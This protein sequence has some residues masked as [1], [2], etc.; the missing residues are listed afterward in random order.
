MQKFKHWNNIIGWA[1]FVVASA[2]YLMT[3]E[4]T[5]SL[6]DCSEFIATSYKLEVGHPPGAPL[7][8][9]LARIAALFAPTPAD[10]PAMINGMNCIASGFCI[11]FL[12]WTI[13]HLVR[14][15]T[16]REGEPI[17]L[18]QILLILGSGVVGALSYAFTDTFWFSAVEGEVYALSSM[19]TALVVWLMLKWEENATSPTAMRW[20][21]LIAYLMGLSIGVHILN[22]LAIP[23]LV[24]I[25]FFRR[26]ECVN[27]K[28]YILMMLAAIVV[29]FLILGAINGIIIPYTVALG[30]AVDTFAVNT[31]GLPV[32]AGMLIFVAA[33][34][35][36][37]GALVWYTHS[38]RYRL[39]NGIA[40]AVTV[41]LIGFGS[42]AAVAIRANANP[43]M[44]S[45]NPSNPHA[46]LSLLNRD[47]Y[48]NRPLIT[49]P[50][51]S[52]KPTPMVVLNDDTSSDDQ[53]I[54]T[55]EYEAKTMTWLNPETGEYEPREIFSDYKYPSEANA[56]FPRMWWHSRAKQYEQQWVSLEAGH[57]TKEVRTASGEVW[58]EPTAGE[59]IAYF[60]D[61]QLGDM[62]VRY[63]MW[64]FVGRQDDIQLTTDATNGIY[65]HGGWLSGIDFIDRHFT[66]PTEN[67]PSDMANNPARNTYFF[68][69]LLL[70]MLGII[71]Q[72][73]SDWKN[74]IIV[75]LLYVMMGVALVVYFNTAPNEPRE[76][77]YVYAGAFYAFSI[78]IGLGAAALGHLLSSVASSFVRHSRI[79]PTAAVAV[80]LL[81]A[82][83]VPTVLVAENWDDHDRSDRYYARDLGMNYLNAAP[84]NAILLN[85]G[86]NDTFPLWYCQ[87]VE[88]VRPD[89]RVM[90]TSYLG[91]EWY[92][93]EMKLAANDAEGVP[94]TI[95]SSKYSFVNDYIIV[96]EPID[97][98]MGDAN[99]KMRA[100]ARRILGAEYYTIYMPDT[101]EEEELTYDELESLYRQAQEIFFEYD[102]DKFYAYLTGAKEVAQEDMH[103]FAE[104]QFALLILEEV[105]YNTKFL[106]DVRTLAEYERKYRKM[107]NA[108]IYLKDALR[109]FMHD[110]ANPNPNAPAEERALLLVV[111]NGIMR[112]VESDKEIAPEERGA[113]FEIMGRINPKGDSFLD[114]TACDYIIAAKNYLIPVDKD[115]AIEAGIVTESERE[116]M[117]DVVRIAISGSYL[118]KDYLMMLDLVANFGWK[119]PLAFTQQYI[120]KDYGLV[121]Y[122]RF[123]GFG[124]TFV[125]IL[126]ESRTSNVGL[127]NH[128][129]LYDMYMGVESYNARPLAFGNVAT[130]G[131]LCDYFTR[132]NLSATRL[133]ENFTRVANGFIGDG[134]RAIDNARYA[135]DA[136]AT[137]DYV[138]TA[139]EAF[140]KA[141]ALLNRGTEVLPNRQVGYDYE[142]TYPYIRAYYNIATSRLM[143][144]LDEY[145]RAI[146]LLNELLGTNV[147][148]EPSMDDLVYTDNNAMAYDD[149]IKTAQHRGIDANN[150]LYA[151]AVA[152]GTNA[153]ALYDESEDAYMRG[154][155]LSAEFIAKRGEWANYYMQFGT[156]E[157]FSPTIN[158]ELNLAIMDIVDVL[159][160]VSTIA[161]S[162]DWVAN[163]T[164]EDA[165]VAQPLQFDRLAERYIATIDRL[166]PRSTR[167]VHFALMESHIFNIYSIYYHLDKSFMGY[168]AGETPYHRAIV[169][170]LNRPEVKSLIETYAHEYGMEAVEVI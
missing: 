37:L 86:D 124:Y 8:M 72:M 140:R 59:D 117:L 71:Y 16:H 2:V 29:S 5:T 157:S 146:E 169:K 97:L 125:P 92:I 40:M 129:A 160:D 4:P 44:N 110:G 47:Q 31:L 79:A 119:R 81:L 80:G 127:L 20:I 84:A 56:L 57:P 94:F 152:H 128:E 107:A 154:D 122:A 9:L 83:S 28:R 168:G 165:L 25:W 112:V 98:L 150:A 85:Y 144:T 123:N 34:F 118:T 167:D 21:I 131:V 35:G 58:Y 77:D 95:P 63:F 156:L 66:G 82:A 166:T 69:P 153:Q 102:S 109:L 36:A 64:N 14:R 45:N 6:W 50:Y 162:Y 108:D 49:G 149:L 22:L 51:Y 43:P 139:R 78:W 136:A 12:F 90:N 141:E 60:L 65:L 1:V 96:A 155:V 121:D 33:V 32:N 38:R 99:V 53:Y 111:N 27:I 145:Q 7:F 48:G 113:D 55:G 134:N 18:H 23:A 54:P 100:E 138:S 3:M 75:A 67:I 120:M 147:E 114:G 116:K 62:F 161:G 106:N 159:T 89:V 91:G 142:N 105:E 126:T 130:E 42:Y 163:P 104:Y 68:L 101:G 151:E 143:L 170:F 74:F 133:R 41:I 103:A 52:A 164:K 135:E 115:A 93:D 13:T 61:Y 26:Y 19:F 88:G 17:Y 70:G 15:I 87:E 132:Y 73:S 148:P 30:A 24:M 11:M 46:L 39:L 10:V 158:H 76:R 137:A